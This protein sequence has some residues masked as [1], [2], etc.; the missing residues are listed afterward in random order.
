MVKV[1]PSLLAADFRVMGAQIERMAEAGADY[2]HFD[3]MDGSFVPNISFGT[4]VLKW[5]AKGPLPVDAHLMVEH[6]HTQVEAFAREGAKI[7]TIHAEAGGHL[8]RTLAL[9]RE[10]GCL[11]GLALNP[12]TSPD[13][14]RY[15]LPSVDLVLVMTVNPGY[16]GQRMIPECLDKIAEIR[17]MLDRA[18]CEA[19][20]EVDG[21]AN[22]D[23]AREMMRRGANVIVAGSALFGAPDA[24]AFIDKLRAD[25]NALERGR[26][27]N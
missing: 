6:P 25:W 10:C 17:S 14:L 16:G 24:K 11:A 20:L 27:T 15:L 2:L 7:I 5:A 4:E 8:H 23:P 22:L 3:V 12:G 9:I 18:G 21:G 13:C 26:A 1:A 19:M